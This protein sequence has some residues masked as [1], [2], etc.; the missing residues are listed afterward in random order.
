MSC[1]EAAQI[2][3]KARENIPDDG[4]TP[5]YEIWLQRIQAQLSKERDTSYT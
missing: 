3:D 1:E 2:A 4:H 5:M